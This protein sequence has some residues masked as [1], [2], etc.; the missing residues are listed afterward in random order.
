[1]ALTR[2][3]SPNFAAYVWG[4]DFPMF[5]RNGVKKET[6]RRWMGQGANFPERV[7]VGKCIIKDA[8]FAKSYFTP[9]RLFMQHEMEQYMLTEGKQGSREEKKKHREFLK[10]HF[11]V[12]PQ[13]IAGLCK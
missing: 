2:L 8:E 10:E 13:D 11:K 4:E 6:F 12:L 7:P 5:E 3:Y 9:K 1:M